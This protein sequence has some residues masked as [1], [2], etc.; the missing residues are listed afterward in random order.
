MNIDFH[1]LS[2]DPEL[3]PGY[4]DWVLMQVPLPALRVMLRCGARA[5]R[6]YRFAPI[7]DTPHY[8][9]TTT[10]DSAAYRQYMETYGEEV[11]HGVE[12]NPEKFKALAG[13]L[14]YLKTPHERS[15]IVVEVRMMNGAPAYV[16]LDG[17]HRL[18]ILAARG[19]TAIPV[20]VKNI[21]NGRKLRQAIF[22]ESFKNHSATQHA[23]FLKCAKEMGCVGVK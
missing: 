9:F 8:R 5:A 23:A 3:P 4:D 13:S 16:V 19:E 7:Q 10:G 1:T 21:Q 14:D 12:H 22:V 20:I 18:A 6:Q 2:I 17:F 11:G 15:Y